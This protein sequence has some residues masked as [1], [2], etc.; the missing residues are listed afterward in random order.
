M[1]LLV[2]L[3][4]IGLSIASPCIHKEVTAGIRMERMT[5]DLSSRIMQNNVSTFS[6]IRILPDFSGV[7]NL[8]QEQ[9]IYIKQK[10]VPSLIDFLQ[11]A[12]KVRALT[13]KLVFKN[14]TCHKASVPAEFSTSGVDVD[15]VLFITAQPYNSSDVVAWASACLL[16][17]IDDR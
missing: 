9:Q 8:T 4:F 7:S 16:S 14:S 1:K 2:L 5:T 12:L 15:L 11:A 13:R 10:L 3:I 17:G 6:P